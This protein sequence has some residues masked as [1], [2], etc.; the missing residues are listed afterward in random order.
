MGRQIIR[1]GLRQRLDQR[2]SA[3]RLYCQ[4][5]FQHRQPNRIPIHLP[6]NRIQGGT[7][8]IHGKFLNNNATLHSLAEYE[9]D[10][11]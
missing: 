2:G 8:N 7:G 6:G 4:S 1:R 10:A 5:L 9:Q 11:S 3:L